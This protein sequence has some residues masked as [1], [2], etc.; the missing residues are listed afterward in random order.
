MALIAFD[1]SRTWNILVA[2]PLNRKQDEKLFIYIVCDHK[3][4]ILVGEIF[5]ISLHLQWKIIICIQYLNKFKKFI[6]SVSLNC[7]YGSSCLAKSWA[8]ESWKS[9]TL[10]F[11]SE[12]CVMW[13]FHYIFD[14]I[15]QKNQIPSRACS[16]TGPSKWY[17]DGFVLFFQHG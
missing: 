2:P 11:L 1:T 3:T 7:C 10:R 16:S 17:I 15:N 4:H 5:T 9:E 13:T 14:K 12:M 8:W 6:V